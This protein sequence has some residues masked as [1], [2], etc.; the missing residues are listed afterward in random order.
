MALTITTA[1]S[2]PSAAKLVGVGVF[3]DDDR[4]PP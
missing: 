3:T 4:S 1:R 2:A